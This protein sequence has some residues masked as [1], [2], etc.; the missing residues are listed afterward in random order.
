MPTSNNSTERF[1]RL[2]KDE[3]T[4]HE[5]ETCA[6]FLEYSCRRWISVRSKVEESDPWREN[7]NITKE[8]WD[9][10]QNLSKNEL[11]WKYSEEMLG[12]TMIA[13]PCS[14]LFARVSKKAV[15]AAQTELKAA[16]KLYLDMPVGCERFQLPKYLD[17]YYSFYILTELSPAKRTAHTFYACTCPY[18]AHKRACKH[19]VAYGL[20][21]KRFTVPKKRVN[22]AINEKTAV[23]PGRVQKAKPGTALQRM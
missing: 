23:Q 20:L 8:V 6:A 22:T 3:A 17:T 14:E 12:G 18:Y 10:A 7:P 4:F 15:A 11:Y 21:K 9:V 5:R 2:I 19:S 13:V 1:N 16:L